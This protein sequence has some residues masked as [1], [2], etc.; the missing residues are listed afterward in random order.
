MSRYLLVISLV[1]I[2][3][4]DLS[5][6]FRGIVELGELGGRV[7]TSRKVHLKIKKEKT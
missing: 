2:L 1:A 5:D 4:A 3:V 7:M 6:F